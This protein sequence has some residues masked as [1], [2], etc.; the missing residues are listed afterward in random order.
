MIHRPTVQYLIAAFLASGTVPAA[1]FAQHEGHQAKAPVQE[2]GARKGEK[3][4]GDPYP[5]STCP[6]TGEQLGGMGEPFVKLYDGREV[7]FCCDGCTEGFE[8]DKA[9]N[10]AKL[11][12]KIVKDQLPL[13]PLRTSVVS[14]KDLPEHPVDFVFGN[15][16]VR[17]RDEAERAEFQK[18]PKRHL[19][20]LDTAVVAA[21]GA[22]YVLAACPV[23]G[24][25]YGGAMGEP[26]DVVVAGRLVRLCC[27]G[28]KK[29]VETDPAKFVA[30]VDAARKG[31]PHHDD[32]GG[33]HM[34]H[35]HK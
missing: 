8:K 30:L 13:Y 7:R 5:F 34:H 32:K 16:L 12:E 19:A 15:R 17:V 6:V 3:R 33:D 23:S 21:Q 31:E 10:F 29:D 35:E 28:C 14:G 4:V 26:V 22:G 2:E 27:K 11:D 9:G 24:E 1:T 20:V 25:E 18:D